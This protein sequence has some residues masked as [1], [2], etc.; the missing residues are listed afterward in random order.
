MKVVLTKDVRDM[1]RAGSVMEVSDGHAINFLIPRKMAVPATLQAV[2]NAELRQKQEA[3][4]KVIDA[5]LL[6]QNI[7]A[8][9]DAHIVLTMKANDKGHLYESVSVPEIVA[10]VKSQARIDLPEEAIKL[11]KH[12]K[13]IGEFEVP[14]LAGETSGTFSILIEAQA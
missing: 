2:K 10:A 3:D 9:K 11:D 5:G 13:E 8:L 12:I 4:R 7:A 1:G 14:V 6:K